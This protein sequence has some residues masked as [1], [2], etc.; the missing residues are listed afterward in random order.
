MFLHCSINLILASC[1]W[2]LIFFVKI[3]QAFH[4]QDL[5]EKNTTY[6]RTRKKTVVPWPRPRRSL[7]RP[8]CSW[9]HQ[10]ASFYSDFPISEVPKVT[11]G[12][13]QWHQWHRTGLPE[14]PP[15]TDPKDECHRFKVMKRRNERRDG[16]GVGPH[17]S[18]THSA[19]KSIEV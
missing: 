12:R 14:P 16:S 2:C 5:G 13:H 18:I 9:N 15:A 3:P 11:N 10:M 4:S 8:P 7:C 6:Q 19:G 17:Q 1:I